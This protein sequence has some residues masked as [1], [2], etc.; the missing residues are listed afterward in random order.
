VC[1]WCEIVHFLNKIHGWQKL[2]EEEEEEEEEFGRIEQS[3]GRAMRRKLMF[4]W[5]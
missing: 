1:V 2:N 3:I 4:C 5:E